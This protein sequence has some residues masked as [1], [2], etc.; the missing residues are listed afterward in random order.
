MISIILPSKSEPNILKTLAE[1]D[2]IFP[3]AQ[4]IVCNDRYGYGKGWAVREALKHAIGD[5]IVF[6]DADGDIS[7]R[8][9]L[10]LLP[11]LQEFD[12]VVGKKDLRGFVSRR[13]ITILSRVYIYLLFK[14]KVD[15]QTGVKAFKRSALPDW[16]S[17]GFEFDFEILAKAQKA[18]A[19]IYEITIDAN[20]VR[21][22]KLISLWKTFI[23]SIRVWRRLCT[24]P[25]SG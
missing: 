22:M 23:G 25:I 3:D 14:V 16:V 10:R 6:L 11:H 20:I 13:I 12:I 9:I 21:K 15:T 2:K 24:N 1:I 18:G 17:N 7:P 4:T 19:S 5:I 8:M